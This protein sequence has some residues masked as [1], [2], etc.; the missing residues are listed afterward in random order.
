MNPMKLEKPV[1]IAAVAAVLS[2]G[3][4][5]ASYVYMQNAYDAVTPA[6][7]ITPTPTISISPTVTP[8]ATLS[9]ATPKPT[10]SPTPTGFTQTPAEISK[11]KTT[12]KRVV[13]TFDAG[14][15]NQSADKILA[16]L[17]KHKVKG[18]YFVTGKWVEQNTNATKQ[19]ATAGHEIFNHTYSHPYLTKVTESVIVTEFQKTEDIIRNATGKTSKPYFRPPYGDRNAQVLNIAAKKGYQSVY[20]TTDALDWQPEMTNEKVKARILNSLTPGAIYLMH[21]GDTITGDILDEVFTEIKAR[22]YTIMSLT[23]GLK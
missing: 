3:L 18:T 6:P 5:S 4:A 22:G 23:E 8:S 20:W 7:V 21:I 19:I 17:A 14:A 12:D 16:V 13:F 1:L 15:G 9:P 10:P 11:V 2:V